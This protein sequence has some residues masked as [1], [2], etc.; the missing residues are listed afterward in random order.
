M[1]KWIFDVKLEKRQYY[2]VAANEQEM[3]A[4]VHDLCQVC[5]LEREEPLANPGEGKDAKTMP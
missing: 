3:N 4:W 2:L 5:N 1:Y